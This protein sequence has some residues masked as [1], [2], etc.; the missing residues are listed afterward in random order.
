MAA[1]VKRWV[2]LRRKSPG[3]RRVAI[4]MYGFPPGVGATGTAALLNVPRSLEGLLR[5]MR[6]EG[7]DLGLGAADAPS[8]T[9]TTARRTEIHGGGG[10]G[11]GA[12]GWALDGEALISGLKMQ[13]D[14]RAVSE[15][16]AGMRRKGVGAAAEA[17]GF[18]AA[19]AE[20]S[21]AELKV[22]PPQ[23]ACRR[24]HLDLLCSDISEF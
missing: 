19:V 4:L 23:T 13:E 17:A 21:P 15:G 10:G 5:R 3:E 16:A 7:Y 14:Q 22:C 20:V 24:L 18:S 12:G 2:E 8:A 6:D 9:G 1:R 11:A